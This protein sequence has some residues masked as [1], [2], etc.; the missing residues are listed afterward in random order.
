VVKLRERISVSKRARQN[1][2]LEGFELKNLDDLE[3][4]EKHQVEISN[5]FK[6]LGSLDESFDS[7]NA[8]EGIR[9]KI[10][11]SAE[12]CLGYQKLK[13]KK[14][15]FVDECSKL[16]GKQ[17]RAKLQWLQNPTEIN[18][19]NLQNLRR[20]T[21]TTFKK[22]IREYLKGKINELETN[23]KNRNIRDL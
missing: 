8:S 11:T 1:F 9:E 14:Q 16:L 22:K 7:N 12:E 18:A 6:A 21:S 2:D 19:H 3:V 17:K 13:H 20:E 23:N 15:W 10:K 4:R 5:L